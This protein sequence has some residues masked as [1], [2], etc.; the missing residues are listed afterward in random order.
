MVEPP[1][2]LHIKSEALIGIYEWVL[3]GEAVLEILVLN[4]SP[5]VR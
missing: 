3:G 4:M 1:H 5:F 2:H